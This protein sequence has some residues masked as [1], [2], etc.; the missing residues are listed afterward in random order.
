MIP[1]DLIEK[2]VCNVLGVTPA[3]LHQ[4]SRKREICETRQIV[5]YFALL[6]G[7]T[8]RLAAKFYNLDHATSIHSRKKVYNIYAT[9][10][11]FRNSIDTIHKKLYSEDNNQLIYLETIEKIAI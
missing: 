3:S 1:I 6:E 8:L 10:K 4:K 9:E 7:Y 11:A 2:V 5:L